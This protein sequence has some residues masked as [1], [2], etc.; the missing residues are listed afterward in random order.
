MVSHGVLSWISPA[1]RAHLIGTI[2]RRLKPG[3]LAYL[4]YNV[5]TGWTSMV[6]VRAL[7]HMLA[8]ASPQRTDLAA[9]RACWTSSIG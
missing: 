5:T 1:N 4:S 8:V 2:A 7:M 3:G 9:C 6:P